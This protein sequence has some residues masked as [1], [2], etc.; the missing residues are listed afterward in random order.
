MRF[1]C[2]QCRQHLEPQQHGY[3]C[4]ACDRTYPVIC[5]IPDL[6]L[7]PDPYISLED[8]RSKGEMLHAAISGMTFADAVRYYYAITP[9]DPADL[10]AIWTAR[11]LVEVEIAGQILTYAPSHHGNLL[12]VGCSTGAALIAAGGGTGVDVAFRWLVLG[13]LRLR[14]AGVN[15]TLVC[16]NAEH[17]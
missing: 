11:A 16:A 13:Q 10:A 2:P 14:E 4:F 5:G 9:E 7:Y 15:A 6:R 1:V 8:D 3:S 17:L 12:D